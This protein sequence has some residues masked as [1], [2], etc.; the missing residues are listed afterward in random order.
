MSSSIQ[1]R[2]VAL[3]VVCLMSQA[4]PASAYNWKTHKDI[5]I[6]AVEIAQSPPPFTNPPPGVTLAEWLHFLA[7][8]NASPSRL[9]RLRTGLPTSIPT[10]DGIDLPIFDEP[11]PIYDSNCPFYPDDN[12][13]KIGLMQ[14]KDFRYIALR[15]GPC[16]IQAVKTPEEQSMVLP[17]VLGWQAGSPDDHLMDTVMWYRPTN[18]GPL[19]LGKQIL[20]KAWKVG[21]GSAVAPFKCAWD[22][23][24]GSGCDFGSAYDLAD[25]YNPVEYVD[26]WIPGLSSHTNSTYPGVWH[27]INMAHPHDAGRYNDF[28]GLWYQNAGPNGNPGVID[29][30]IMVG[31]NTTGLSLNAYSSR[32]DD[33]Y[34][35]YDRVSRGTLAWHA[36][37]VAHTEFSP[38]DNLAQYGW[39]KFRNEGR[40]S[41]RGF[42]WPL[43]A[44]A[45]AACPH[46]V[47]GTTSFG[48]RPFED[49][50]EPAFPR[51]IDRADEA[52]RTR[53][54]QDAYFWWREF[55]ASNEDIRGLVRTVAFQTHSL[56]SVGG[57]WPFNDSASY[58]YHAVSKSEG[59]HFYEGLGRDLE[60]A[61]LLEISIGA[62]LGFL[63]AASE[64]VVD[65]GFDPSTK[66][67]PGTHYSPPFGACMPG[68]A[69]TPPPPI[70]A[71]LCPSAG[72]CADGGDAAAD[73]TPD[74]PVCQIPCANVNDC[75]SPITYICHTGCCSPVPT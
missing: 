62:S 56:A 66:C 36:Y 50:I 63:L 53:I 19:S 11:Y 23:I 52:Q 39:D 70:P 6:T 61:R 45:D 73:A 13:A 28:P 64:T 60:A 65:P 33:N 67:P 38:V 12:L 17:N 57:G 21:F 4:L 69:P 40:N 25:E 58:E 18:V 26:S 14:I 51:L 74:G 2:L 35:Q 55:K 5:V 31:A 8:V 75:P 68:D 22:A 34:G 10:N 41:A 29:I 43:H 3:I 24:F 16:A 15:N 44:I 71:H 49:Y 54:L 59:I 47:V 72:A 46:H 7:I 9:G 42:A 1:R 37:N 27:F 30:L 48:H 32:G 20:S